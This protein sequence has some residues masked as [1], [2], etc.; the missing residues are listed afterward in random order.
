MDMDDQTLLYLLIGI[1]VFVIVLILWSRRSD[2]YAISPDVRKRWEFGDVANVSGRGYA[3]MA[4]TQPQECDMRYQV[5]RRRC[6]TQRDHED[7]REEL[8]FCRELD[9]VV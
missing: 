5:C 3:W 4:G 8:E 7:C 9:A 1:F 6:L 2:G